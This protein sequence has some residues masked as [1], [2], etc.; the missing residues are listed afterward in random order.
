MDL[1]SA[2]LHVTGQILVYVSLTDSE[3]ALHPSLPVRPRAKLENGQ[4]GNHG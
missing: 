3:D 1:T 2:C 4:R